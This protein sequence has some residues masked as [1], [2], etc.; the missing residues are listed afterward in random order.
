MPSDARALLRPMPW[1]IGTLLISCRITFVPAML[2]FRTSSHSSLPDCEPMDAATQG[3][4]LLVHCRHSASVCIA[5]RPVLEGYSPYFRRIRWLLSEHVV[6]GLAGLYWPGSVMCLKVDDPVGCVSEEM[7]R[8]SD[9]DGIMYMHF[10]AVLSPCKLLHR[11]DITAVSTFN[12]RTSQRYATFKDF[13]KC[14]ENY[15]NSST[16]CKWW[17]WDRSGH[18]VRDAYL[19]ALDAVAVVKPALD[20]AELRMGVRF[21]LND[22]FYVPRAA[23]TAYIQLAR[24]FLQWSDV[25]HHEILGPT[26]L[27]LTARSL[28]ANATPA[29]LR[30]WGAQTYSL[31]LE[32]LNSTSFRCGHKVDYRNPLNVDA[33]KKVQQCLCWLSLQTGEEQTVWME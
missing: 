11:M 18:R 16:N 8:D 4:T 23:F 29:D 9:S 2:Q 12:T 24:I 32:H 25:V 19:A 14:N 30:C 5:R 13:E 28:Q 33:V 22:L 7:A 10:D 27:A 17:W 1:S 15:F 20:L 31:R 6:S 21:G 3:V 26:A